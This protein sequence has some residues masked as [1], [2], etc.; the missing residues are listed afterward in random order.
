MPPANLML[1]L[2]LTFRV[3]ACQQ[4]WCSD[5]RRQITRQRMLFVSVCVVPRACPK[6]RTM[7]WRAI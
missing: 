1:T 7:L 5:D 4:S 2:Y 3:E 6:P